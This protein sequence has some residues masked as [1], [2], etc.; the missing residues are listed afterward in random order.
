MPRVKVDPGP[1]AG[2]A[3]PDERRRVRTRWAALLAL[4][5]LCVALLRVAHVPASL[6]LGTMAAGVAVAVTR[7]PVAVPR[8]AFVLAQGI[9][10]VLI[11][12]RFSPHV[13]RSV[14]K[15]WA[16]YLFVTLGVLALS[17]LLG[18]LL[19]RWQV[20]PGTTGLWGL[21]PGAATAMV[22]MAD[23]YGA[24]MRLVAFMQYLRVLLV[25]ALASAI[26]Q[27]LGPEAART[28]AAAPWFG[29][30]DG[31]RLAATLAL[32]LAGSAA[33]HLSRIPAGA[34]IVSFAI[35]SALNASGVLAPELPM[36]LLAG[37]YAVIGW[38]V[39]LRFTREILAHAA[40]VL[41]RVL[42]AILAL[43]AACAALAVPVARIAGVHPLTAFLATSPGGADTVAIIAASSGREDMAFAMAFQ[44]VR[45][46]VVTFL[47][48]HIARFLADRVD[49]APEA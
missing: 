17:V 42:A 31:A 8:W 19:A 14:A 22:V 15:G 39:G 43:I 45:A 6:L 16:L 30:M 35:G 27:R 40:R 7:G 38:T 10:G 24:D 47:G 28:A 41:P 36:W 49:A 32:I 11:S 20:L 3:P 13:A 33:G 18:W 25:A 37:S 4:S 5:A 46:V 44:M 29:P 26:A 48:P 23:A 2:V 9:V 12:A 1:R 21:S 34:L